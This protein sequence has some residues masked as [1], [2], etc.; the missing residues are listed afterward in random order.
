MK[1]KNIFKISIA[2][3]LC[4]IALVGCNK[5]KEN[6]D[7]I[8]EKDKNHLQVLLDSD[9][10]TL[11][12]SKTVDT[13]SSQVLTNVMEGLTRI[14][15]D[16]NGEDIIKPAGAEKWSVSDDGLVWT[17]KLRDMKWS[18]GQPVKVEDYIYGITRT[19]SPK[20]NSPYAFLLYPIKNAEDFNLGQVPERELGVKKIDESTLQITL[21]VPTA[22]FLNLTYF[23]VMEPQ[24]QDIVEKYGELYGSGS[25]YMVYTGPFIISRWTHDDEIQLVKNKKYWDEKSVKLEKIT[26]KVVQDEER[27]MNELLN[28]DLDIANVYDKITIEKLNDSNSFN[29]KK[30]YDGSVNYTIFNQQDEYFKNNKI[31]KAFIIAAAREEACED[32]FRNL[33]E[34]ALGWCPPGVQLGSEEYRTNVNYFP[35]NN[36]KKEYDNPKQ[37]LIEGLKELGLDPDPKNHTFKYLQSEINEKSKYYSELEKSIFEKKLGVN[38][39]IEYVGWVEFQQK[40]RA[41]DYQ[42]AA[43][44][45]IGDYNDPS[46]F[47]DIWSSTAGIIQTG[48]SNEKYDRLIREASRT[49]NQKSRMELFNEAEKILVEEDSVISPCLWKI[50]N[51]YVRKE[52]KNFTR[53]MWGT[54]DFKY[55]YIEQ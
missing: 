44:S 24:R 50:R 1:F 40:T 7:K 12:Q 32:D 27:K 18:D 8:V 42:M 28:G 45:W 4:M 53:P 13:Y 35:V 52:I 16:E 34:P 48:W 55:T 11:D 37:L 47:F 36:L 22:Y 14:E 39:D 15:V 6:K 19:L 31:R 30:G 51:I 5:G 41:M 54:I 49:N 26:M 2:V 33:A 23:K 21:E 46:T 43:Q 17:F 9:P 3:I 38:I 25:Q 20:V 29:I 10:K